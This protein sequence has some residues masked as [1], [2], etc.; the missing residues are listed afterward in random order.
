MIGALL[1][2]VGLFLLGMKLLTEGLQAAAGD[3]LQ[4]GLRRYTDTPLRAIGAG[5]VGTALVQS[6]SAVTLATIGFVSAGL[7]STQA[8][9]GVIFGANLGT[10]AT[11]WIVAS[12]GLKLKIDTLALPLVGVGAAMDQFGHGLR[13]HQGRALAGFGLIF[14]GIGALQE[15]MAGLS[16]T[17]D[18]A[19]LALPGFGGQLL[20]VVF[21]AATTVILQSSSAAI[22]TTLAA[23]STGTLHFE[24]AAAVVIGQ[25]LGTTLT[26]AIGAAGGGAPSRRA[27]A[28]HVIFNAVTAITA[29][30]VL[31]PFTAAVLWATSGIPGADTTLAL[32]A[33]HSAFNLLGLA[34]FAPQTARLARFL[35]RVIPERHRGLTARLPASTG[36][37]VVEVSL[38]AGRRTAIEVAAAVV[39]LVHAACDPGAPPPPWPAD[40]V[41]S[42]L[43]ELDDFLRP[44]RTDPTSAAQFQQHL[45]VLHAMDRLHALAALAA[46]PPPTEALPEPMRVA[47]IQ[48][49]HAAA[50]AL[51][52]GSPAGASSPDLAALRHASRAELLEATARGAISAP[53]A[54]AALMALAWAEQAG[55]HLER[56][57][58]DL[59]G[60][61][62]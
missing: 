50:A 7:L 38:E 18:P 59:A 16:A 56:V 13:A 4:A 5:A 45:A 43:R 35:E 26:A 44:L 40:A 19:A 22:T 54:Q 37:G 31:Q 27:A 34:I 1:G 41:R 47:L 51:L 2:G 20:L 55:A 42:A 11:A 62:A 17:Y 60:P 12:V 24:Q 36:T 8:A 61:R 46:Q 10:T 21:G 3:A 14:V 32:A 49:A 48:R 23:L 30:V 25:N 9:L 33:F 58:D 53:E 39:A 57:V 29:L 6:S 15:G 52:A 28:G